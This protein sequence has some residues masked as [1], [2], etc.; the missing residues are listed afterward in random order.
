[1][2]DDNVKPLFA[3]AQPAESAELPRP[4]YLDAV[5]AALDIAG[6]RILAL[7]AVIGSVGIWTYASLDPSLLRLY[8]GV[9]CSAGVL[10][11]CLLF[12]IKRG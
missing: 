11:P 6:A 3:T 7:I 10:I 8:A 1:M 4:G 5:H 12:Y 2:A 9:G